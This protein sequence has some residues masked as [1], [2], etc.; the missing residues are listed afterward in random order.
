MLM[1]LELVVSQLII[2]LTLINKQ[3]LALILTLVIAYK[4]LSE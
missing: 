1:S 3:E 4:F 2:I